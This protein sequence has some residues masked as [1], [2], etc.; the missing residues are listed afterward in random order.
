VGTNGTWCFL[1]VY[2]PGPP[3]GV[4]YT[5]SS[6]GSSTECFTVFQIATTTVTT[7]S[8]GS[9]GTTPFGSMVSDM[10]VVTAAQAGDGT[11]TGTVTF[12]VCDPTQTIGG[13]CP[14]GGSQVGKDPVPTMDL[15]TTPPSSTA[16]SALVTVTM[17][18]T[19]CFRAVYTPGGAN[20]SHYT[21]SSDAS[22]G[23][24]FTVNDTTMSTSAQNW[25]PND[26]ATV[27]PANGAPLNGTLSAQ[28]YTDGTCGTT[29]GT[30]VPGQLYTKTLTNATT[31]TSLTTS[32]TTFKVTA[33]TAVSWQVTFT[34][35]DPNV[36]GSMHCESTSLTINNN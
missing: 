12:F 29:G 18:G 8:V 4:D 7:P 17:T 5:G 11:P 34:S 35:S 9:G 10:A 33:S 19:W 20:G 27:T 2:A 3:N 6:D 30:A 13:A 25:L 1:A 26:M 16:T 22:S 23:E 24:C 15:G 32:N 14:T 31:D 36:K 21:G 28:L